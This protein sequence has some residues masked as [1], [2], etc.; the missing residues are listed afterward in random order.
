MVVIYCKSGIAVRIRSLYLCNIKLLLNQ[1]YE[2]QCILP[3]IIQKD[4]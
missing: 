3:D 2:L 4:R 1:R